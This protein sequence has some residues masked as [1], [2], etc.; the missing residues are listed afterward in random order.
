MNQLLLSIIIPAYNA[1]KTIKKTIQSIFEGFL[2]PLEIIVVEN[3]STDRTTE[4]LENLSDSNVIICHSVKGVSNAR[5]VGIQ[6][7]KGK[8]IMFVDA[9]DLIVNGYS[10]QL[11]AILKES[12][13]DLCLFSKVINNKI[14]KICSE[15]ESISTSSK[16]EFVI[17]TMS[18]PTIY[19]LVNS[20]VFKSETLK[21]SEIMFDTNMKY[22]EDSDF[23]LRYLKSCN[24]I[25]L[26]PWPIYE[27][28]ANR[29]SLTHLVSKDK[30]YDYANSM[31]IT[32]KSLELYDKDLV[33]AYYNYVLT[34]FN[35]VM[36]N[37]TFSYFNS[38]S[39]KE[40]VEELKKATK[41]EPFQTAI[42]KI[43][44]MHSD[45]VNGF[46]GFLLRNH[47]FRIASKIY[48]MRAKQK[49]KEVDI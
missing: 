10:K 44:V 41:I 43:D 34:N 49:Y 28:V 14:I 16:K 48:R 45:I 26:Y 32:E 40:A 37:N 12:N 33:N 21:L 18:K 22:A 23:V 11:E 5:N 31:V 1:E 13:S 7:A 2:F 3:G 47:M 9:D 20:K 17:K 46:L 25:E 15:Y 8:W 19:G 6:Q 39:N 35:I 42:R 4:I 24:Q 36:V 29:N 38:I 30:I 27:V